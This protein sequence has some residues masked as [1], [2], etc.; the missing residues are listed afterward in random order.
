MFNVVGL[1]LDAILAG[2]RLQVS[3]YLIKSPVLAKS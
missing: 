1:E 2:L 3:E